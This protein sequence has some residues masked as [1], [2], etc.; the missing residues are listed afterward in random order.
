MHH[1]TSLQELHYV[2]RRRPC[3]GAS[4]ERSSTASAV[5]P[6]HGARHGRAGL[7]RH[8]CTHVGSEAEAVR[9]PVYHCMRTS[10]LALRRQHAASVIAAA[11]GT[12]SLAP[13]LWRA[14]SLCPREARGR[15]TAWSEWKKRLGL[16][17]RGTNAAPASVA[18]SWRLVNQST[19]GGLSCRRVTCETS[20]T[21]S[22][23]QRS[24]LRGQRSCY[25]SDETA[26][27]TSSPR[28]CGSLP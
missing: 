23:V 6:V 1:E 17:D 13:K 3:H 22:G 25:V 10:W 16:A 4:I 21:M 15:T 28:A 19:Q 12:Q 11:A 14:G 9:Q 26:V 7:H 20:A 5:L 24:S 18:A 8:R 27:Q 2:V